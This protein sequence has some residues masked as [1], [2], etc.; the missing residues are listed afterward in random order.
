MIIMMIIKVK[1]KVLPIH[2]MKTYMGSWGLALLTL[3]LGIR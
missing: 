3:N 2:A 1:Y